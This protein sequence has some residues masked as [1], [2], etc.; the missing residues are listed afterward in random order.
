MVSQNFGEATVLKI[1]NYST[2]PKNYPWQL[3]P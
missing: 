2:V 1:M 3:S